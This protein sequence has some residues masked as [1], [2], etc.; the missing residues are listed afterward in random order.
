MLRNRL[1]QSPR[2]RSP[3]PNLQNVSNIRHYY[4]DDSSADVFS[5]SDI[6]SFSSDASA[7]HPITHR[8]KHRKPLKEKQ[9]EDTIATQ[10]FVHEKGMYTPTEGNSQKTNSR[11]NLKVSEHVKFSNLNSRLTLDGVSNKTRSCVTSRNVSSMYGADSQ[12]PSTYND[13]N[14]L[15]EEQ[16]QEIIRQKMLLLDKYNEK[17]SQRKNTVQYK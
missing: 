10:P 8:K 15:S 6:P 1:G 17:I 2:K 14:S 13:I 16:I 7:R 12:F 11:Y 9:G 4:D 3:T 5:N